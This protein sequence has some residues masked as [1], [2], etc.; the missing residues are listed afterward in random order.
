MI[1][2]RSSRPVLHTVCNRLLL[3]AVLLLAIL[4]APLQPGLL[5]GPAERLASESQAHAQ[6][7]SPFVVDGEPLD[8]DA[9]W[10]PDGNLCR[11]DGPAC[12]S[13]P[14]ND[15][16][17]ARGE[18]PQQMQAST[19]FTETSY[20][21]FCEERVNDSDLEMYN[22]CVSLTGFAVIRAETECR[23]LQLRT[24]EVGLQVSLDW[25]RAETRRS[26][27]CP[28]DTIPRNEFPTCYVV[29]TTAP[30]SQ[31]CAGGAPEL[32]LVS[33]ED[34]IGTDFID[35]VMC[36]VYGNG[37][38][39]GDVR[40]LQQRL[41]VRVQRVVPR[42]RVPQPPSLRGLAGRVPQARQRNRRLRRHRPSRPCAATSSR[43]TWHRPNPC[44][45]TPTPHSQTCSTLLRQRTPCA[46][47]GA[48]RARLCR[49]SRFQITAPTTAQT[50]PPTTPS[51]AYNAR[52]STARSSRVSRT[53][54]PD[55]PCGRPPTGVPAWTSTHSS[56]VAVVSSPVVVQV[57]GVPVSFRPAPPPKYGESDGLNV[58]RDLIE[59]DRLRSWAVSPGV[60][61]TPSDS[62]LL[63]TYQIRDPGDD[64]SGAHDLG[65]ESWDCVVEG[66]P[67]F[68]L[69][70]EELWPD[71]D[72]GAIRSL[73]GTVSL[74]WWDAMSEDEQHRRTEHRGLGYWPDLTAEARRLRNEALSTHVECNAE[75]GEA[76]W[77]TW[78]PRRSGYFRLKVGGAWIVHAREDRVWKS[79]SQL[80]QLRHTVRNLDDAGRRR[81]RSNLATL[82]WGP[83]VLGLNNAL[84]DILPTGP[85]DTLTEDI[86]NDVLERD[87][88]HLYW[89]PGDQHRFGG[90][91]LRVR[92]TESRVFAQGAM[93][94]ETQ[95]FGIQVHEVR[96]R[97][98]ASSR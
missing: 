59:L 72:E 94:T 40:S 32:R 48:S 98:V 71:K 27:T 77:C 73:F 53:L 29:Q 15:I 70:V 96:V 21:E 4:V 14:Y 82:G 55:V 83:E 17:R 41:L 74:D 68:T 92:F 47:R 67:A 50:I 89:L 66:L 90:W 16:R 62:S 3:G 52:P 51:P 75:Q 69:F 97:T 25:C 31:V 2:R 34:Y 57:R 79:A 13:S 18:A 85:D 87:P 12:P 22:H 54:R 42:Y 30:P 7:R 45:P 8:C 6:N 9:G 64:F 84:T 5:P 76:A 10:T 24:C 95:T 49:S 46:C 81:V 38:D 11:F 26:W 91:D 39:L 56:G 23:T 37:F 20:P 86:D 78:T 88:D 60:A 44:W 43:T 80:R 33:C 65:N 58:F 28:D 35:S 1:R 61:G 19:D 63:R 36:D 93:Y